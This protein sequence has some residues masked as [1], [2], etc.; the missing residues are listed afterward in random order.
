MRMRAGLNDS[1][2]GY[3]TVN[4]VSGVLVLLRELDESYRVDVI[5]S[6][7]PKAELFRGL[8]LMVS[9]GSGPSAASIMYSP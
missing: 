5:R 9:T 4:E 6:L 8:F 1:L 2:D 3:S 7:T